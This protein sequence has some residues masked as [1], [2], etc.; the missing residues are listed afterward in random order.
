M[1]STWL[2]RSFKE[3]LMNMLPG[4]QQWSCRILTLSSCLM[5]MQLVC[6]HSM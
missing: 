1:E 3:Y 2:Q 4:Q 6:V 5:I